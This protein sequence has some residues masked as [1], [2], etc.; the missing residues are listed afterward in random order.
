MEVRYGRLVHLLLK[1]PQ[2][3]SLGRRTGDSKGQKASENKE[4]LGDHVVDS[5]YLLKRNVGDQVL[6]L[7]G[8]NLSGWKER[9]AENDEESDKETKEWKCT[10]HGYLSGGS[11]K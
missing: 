10:R 5:R 4:R 11:Q 6:E 2:K 1:T 3:C 7:A 9:R 8:E